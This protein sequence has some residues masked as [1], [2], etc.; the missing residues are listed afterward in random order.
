MTKYGRTPTRMF[1][2][3][4]PDLWECAWSEQ[5]H[6]YEMSLKMWSSFVSC[7]A[8]SSLMLAPNIVCGRH[9]CPSFKEMLV[10]WFPDNTLPLNNC[11]WQLVHPFPQPKP[12]SWSNYQVGVV[13][14]GISGS[15]FVR[16]GISHGSLVWEWIFWGVNCPGGTVYRR[17]SSGHSYQPSI[18]KHTGS[19]GSNLQCVVSSSFMFFKGWPCHC[20]LSVRQFFFKFWTGWNQIIHFKEV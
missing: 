7:A 2:Y 12:Y 13:Q 18:G 17:E 1:S 5:L 6:I 4:G 11:P 19:T 8:V 14:G 20:N 3:L 16:V 10:S 9:N 15:G